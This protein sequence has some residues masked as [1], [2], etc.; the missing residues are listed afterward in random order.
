MRE[1]TALQQSVLPTSAPRRA[2]RYARAC[3][4]C[5]SWTRDV[6]AVWLFMR[7]QHA[8]V[9]RGASVTG[10]LRRAAGRPSER[11]A[12]VV[13]TGCAHREVTLAARPCLSTG[14]IDILVYT[15]SVDEVPAEW[16]VRVCDPR[17]NPRVQRASRRAR[18]SEGSASLAR[19]GPFSCCFA[20]ALT[21]ASPR[22]AARVRNRE[23]SDARSI[24][25]AE[26]VS[27]RAFSTKVSCSQLT[28]RCAHIRSARAARSARSAPLINPVRPVYIRTPRHAVSMPPWQAYL[29]AP[30]CLRLVLVLRCTT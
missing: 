11:D 15:D 22:T 21:W 30:A 27:L 20:S 14:S 17:Q 1:A 26:V 5:R 2:R 18:G 19:G 25:N 23:D 16:C 9:A 24:K 10:C 3:P 29:W 4:S 8:H 6:R 12:V 28:P 13:H 7:S